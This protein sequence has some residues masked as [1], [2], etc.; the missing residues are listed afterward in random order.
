MFWPREDIEKT[1]EYQ[2]EP[3]LLLLRRQFRNRRLL[4]KNGL[5]F[6]DQSHHQLSVRIERLLQGSAPRAQLLFALAQ[7]RAEKALHGLREG[8]IRDVALVLVELARGKQA[9]RRHQ[10]FVQ[11]MDDGG[12]ADAG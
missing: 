7:Q 3:A 5:Q 6:R 9:T 1:T 12:F 10:R 4:S 11:L 2:V 8:G